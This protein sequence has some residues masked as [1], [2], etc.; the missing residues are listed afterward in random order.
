MSEQER[1]PYKTQSKSTSKVNRLDKIEAK[2]DE[3]R[4][5]KIQEQKKIE[6]TIEEML[7]TAFDKNEI[8]S[9]TFIFFSTSYFYVSLQGE[10]FPAEIAMSK[11]SLK[12]GVYDTL[13]MLVNPG[14]LPIGAAGPAAAHALKTHKLPLPPQC[15]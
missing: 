6:M 13:H 7:Q 15:A 3:D 12:E 14:K 10:I 11:F 4:F 2:V 5:K 9:T 1:L 8:N